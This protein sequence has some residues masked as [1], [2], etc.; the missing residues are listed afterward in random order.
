SA[1]ELIV[2]LEEKV[3]WVTWR[4]HE[5]EYGLSSFDWVGGKTPT[6]ISIKIEPCDQW[7]MSVEMPYGVFVSRDE[8]PALVAHLA[9]VV[10][11]AVGAKRV[12]AHEVSV[13]RLAEIGESLTL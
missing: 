10:L 5:F 2:S 1:D 12:R 11:D 9:R 4:P 7:E 13:Y 3:R 8:E 6:G